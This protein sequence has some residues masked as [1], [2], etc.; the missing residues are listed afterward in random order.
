[1]SDL[2][3]W[4][5]ELVEKLREQGN[6]PFMPSYSRQREAL[7]HYIN[8]WKRVWVEQKEKDSD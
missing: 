8:E 5:K 7:K 1:M 2:Q 6:K 4:Q 3:P